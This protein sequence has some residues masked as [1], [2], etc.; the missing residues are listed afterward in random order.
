MKNINGNDLQNLT[1]C[2]PFLACSVFFLWTYLYIRKNL[3]EAE[4]A[5]ILILSEKVNM[6][7][8]ASTG[9]GLKPQSD[10]LLLLLLVDYHLVLLQLENWALGVRG[11]LPERLMC[12]CKGS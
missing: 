12:C 9:H 8:I 4:K 6:K 11:T 2:S 10:S 5:F 1:I 7:E 3:S